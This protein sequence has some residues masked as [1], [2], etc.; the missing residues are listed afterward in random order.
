[1]TVT[2]F[3]PS[4]TGYLHIGGLRKLYTSS[5]PDSIQYT[6]LGHLHRFNVFMN[7]NN[8]PIVYSGSILE[9]SFSE[10]MQDKFVMISDITPNAIPQSKKIEIKSGRKLKRGRFADIEK[11]INWLEINKEFF[12]ELTI[13]TNSFIDTETQKKLYSVHD[14]IVSII[15][16]VGSNSK[17]NESLTSFS[18][19][20]DFNT[21]FTNFFK[22]KNK[23]LAPTD[24]IMELLKEVRAME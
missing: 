3:A 21:L 11:A 1:M 22:N 8:Y 14:K 15:P 9:Y 12:V 10:A 19:N 4:P 23:D 7:K 2:R 16:E 17:N 13:V 24:E 20:E 18:L 5:V 6:A